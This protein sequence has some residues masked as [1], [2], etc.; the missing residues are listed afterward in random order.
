MPKK[1]ALDEIS[2]L[3]IALNIN[4][5]IIGGDLNTDFRRVHSPHTS[6]LDEFIEQESFVRCR[7]VDGNKVPFTYESKLNGERSILD[8]FIVTNNISKNVYDVHNPSD[9]LPLFI[10]LDQAGITSCGDLPSG[11]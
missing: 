2:E 9:H 1:N 7:P 8:H 6:M 3:C 10:T 5:V 4:F 11:G